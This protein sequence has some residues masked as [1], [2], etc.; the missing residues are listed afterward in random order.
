MNMSDRFR[1]KSEI[2]S[3]S[4]QIMSYRIWNMEI[5]MYI[6]GLKWISQYQSTMFPLIAFRL[7]CVNAENEEICTPYIVKIC[8]LVNFVNNQWGMAYYFT[9]CWLLSH[10]VLY[11]IWYMS[12]K[13]P[14]QARRG[15]SCKVTHEITLA[16]C[17]THN[18]VD[19]Y[20]CPN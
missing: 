20:I 9:S 11:L 8:S 7:F 12:V 4:K 5:R 15:H 14:G 2:G 18:K 13:W 10:Y 16:F 6:D 3:I 17:R 19:I 1:L